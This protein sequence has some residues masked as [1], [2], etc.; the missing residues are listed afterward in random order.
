MTKQYK[1]AFPQDT[2]TRIKK[3]I[4]SHKLPVVETMLGDGDMFCSCRIS[5]G[6]H[7]DSSIG[8]NGKGMTPD[9]ALASGYAEFMERLQNRVI[10]Y[11]NPASIGRK[12]RFFP[13]ERDYSYDHKEGMRVIRRFIPL[14]V[15]NRNPIFKCLEGKEVPF[16][17][18]NSNECCYLP[19]SLIRWMNGSNG[20]C[21]G[22]IPEE[23]I[24][25][26][27]NEIFERYCI[28]RIYLDKLTPPDIPIEHFEGTEIIRRLEEMKTLY[29]YS[30]KIKDCSL[31]EGF[32]VLGLLIYNPDHSRYIFHLGADLSDTI[33]LERCFTEIFQGYT[34]ENLRFEND[35]NECERLDLYNEFKRSLMYGRGRMHESF[36]STIP[37]YSYTG[38]TTIPIGKDFQ[39]DCANICK[40]L[41]N[42]DYNIY[43]RDNSF[44]GFPT[45]HIVVPGMS[46]IHSTF[47]NIQRRIC[48]MS[49]T[50]NMMNPLYHL[51]SL[52]NDEADIAARF[53]SLLKDDAIDL[54]PRNSSK[55]NH[56]N[57]HL[58][59]SLLYLY[60]GKDEDAKN[61]ISSYIAQCNR[62][63]RIINP[64]FKSLI[65]YMSDGSCRDIKYKSIVQHIL[66]NRSIV[67]GMID[68][69]TCFD[70]IN[71]PVANGCIY[72]LMA[73]VENIVQK[74]MMMHDFKQSQFLNDGV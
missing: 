52:T 26:G 64:V 58:I 72:D 69:P 38:H 35:V 15:V 45:F 41:M 65:E 27:F 9:Y 2:V 48:H 13:D 19:Y 67:L 16:Y 59:L 24:I 50:E 43:I 55:A 46:E 60:L 74:A 29:R 39:E 20:M 8:T 32:P 10:V 31:G 71:C 21:A 61:S 18:Y 62:D 30:Y 34:G 7:N 25:Q 14:S 57:R 23:A 40:W 37:S 3:I 11:P 4:D 54:F 36:F 47:C 5:V 1:A 33:A 56:V 68:S 22:N 17:H 28:Q 51:H 53:L 12:F 73:E 44:L 42:K 6:R 66:D 63:G 49:A 70:C